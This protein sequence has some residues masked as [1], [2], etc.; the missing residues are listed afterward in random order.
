MAAIESATVLGAGS[1]GTALA[2]LLGEQCVK[3]RL[4]MRSADKAD[5]INRTRRNPTVLSD[6]ELSNNIEA[7]ADLPSAVHGTDLLVVA[8]P[9]QSVR[10]VLQPIQDVSS[11]IVLAAKGIET[12]TLMTMHEVVVDVMGEQA[13]G[14]TM[15]LSGPSFAKEMMLG[16]PT[17]VVLAGTDPVLTHDVSKLWFCDRFR[18]YTSADIMGVELGGALKNV[19]AIAAG[20]ITGLG[21]G[22]NTQCA[23]VTRGLAEITR[24]AVS[25]GAEPLTLAGLSGMGDLVLTCTG[26]LSRN[27]RVGQALGE[28]KTLQQALDSIQEVAEGGEHHQVGLRFGSRAG[29]R[30]A[31]HRSGLQGVVRVV[32]GARCHLVFGTTRTGQRT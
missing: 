6:F 29:G 22:H 28:G 20:V 1:F 27:R 25:K 4:W 10:D 15:A 14:K 18:A 21:L 30:C 24:I 3:T 8:I 17:A 9:S 2:H 19:M 13:A 31:Y 16:Y 26:G 23:L 32:A 7:T 12:K 5:T 11:P